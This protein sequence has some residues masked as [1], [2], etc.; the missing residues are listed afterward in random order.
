MRAPLASWS[1][2]AAAALALATLVGGCVDQAPEQDDAA[3]LGSGAL[4]SVDT[5]GF[6]DVVGFHFTIDRVACD[7]ADTF[8]PMRIEADVDLLDLVLPGDFELLDHQADEESRA[9]AADLFVPLQP[10]CY[11]V[12]AYPASDFVASGWV[13]SDDCAP[14]TA[15]DVAV[16]DGLS[17]EVVLISQC[18]NDDAR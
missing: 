1:L 15:D 13:P 17:E 2:R 8:H 3:G 4:L 14:S 18:Q 6:T 12:D 9:L 7:A 5:V 16:L 11:R 10:G